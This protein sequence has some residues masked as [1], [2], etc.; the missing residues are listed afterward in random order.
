MHTVGAA[1]AIVALFLYSLLP[2]VRGAY[3][4]VDR[5]P[6]GSQRIGGFAGITTRC[7]FAPDRITT[8]FTVYLVGY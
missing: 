5:Y 2:I 4:G 1:P 6:S 8:R 7:A 3:T